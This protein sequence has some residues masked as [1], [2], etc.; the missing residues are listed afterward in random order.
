MFSSRLRP[1]IRPELDDEPLHRVILATRPRQEMHGLG[2]E[3]THAVWEPVAD[4]LRATGPDWDRRVHRISALAHALPPAVADAWAARRAGD[5]DAL[6]VRA[7]AYV[8]LRAVSR[9][10]D[11]CLDA[12]AAYPNDPT[13]WIARLSLL[14]RCRIVA[15]GSELWK[16]IVTR[17]PLNRAAHHEMLRYLSPRTCGETPFAMRDFAQ[18]CAHDL[19]HGSPLAVLPLAARAEHYAHRL[20]R[21]KRRRDAP[22]LSG[23]WYGPA[24]VREIEDAFDRWFHGGAPP[25]AQAVADLNVLAF[26]LVMT[27]QTRRAEAVFRRLGRYMTPFPWDTGPDPAGTFAYWQRRA[28]AR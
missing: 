28:R 18:E 5:R 9:A 6:A 14:R 15:G 21:A 3:R 8:G 17:D 20:E 2:T 25:H 24:V 13:P 10:E 16:E 12:V 26:A 1:W 4:L 27:Q 7:N 22:D 11:A 19:P 23:H